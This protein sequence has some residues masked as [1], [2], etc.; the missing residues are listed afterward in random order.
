M[1]RQLRVQEPGLYHVGARGNNGQ[2]IFDDALREIFLSQLTLVAQAFAWDVYAWALMSNH[3]HLLLGV[4]DDG[5][6]VGMHR[7][8]LGFARAS[9]ARFER[10]NHC[11]GDRYWNGPIET[12]GHLYA[13]VRYVLWNPVRA[14]VVHDPFDST[15]TSARSSAGLEVRSE[16]LALGRLLPFFGNAA[17]LAHEGLHDFVLAGRDRCLQP[18]QDGFGIVR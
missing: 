6:A 10:I 4:H 3:F 15:W 9:N 17:A 2:Q 14:G 8:N 1:P 12:D 11:V 13:C 18:W 5:L 7:L 16:P